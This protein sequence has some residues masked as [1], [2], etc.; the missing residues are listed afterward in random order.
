MDVINHAIFL[1]SAFQPNATP[2]FQFGANNAQTNQ[3][4]N[5]VFKFSASQNNN[6]TPANTQNASAGNASGGFNF[7][8][9]QA[10]S[11]NFGATAPSAPSAGA[12][13]FQF[14]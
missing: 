9:Q 5:S 14:K 8:A 6:A 13:P 1:T 4:Q 11:F 3:Q 7:N 2:A 12:S 10:P